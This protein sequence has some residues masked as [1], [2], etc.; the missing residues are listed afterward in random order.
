MKVAK[1]RIEK[2]RGIKD[3]TLKFPDHV[4]LVGDNNVGKSTVFEALDLVLGPDRLNRRPKID[5]HDFHLG[6]YVSAKDE[7]RK[8]VRIET[9]VTGLS[10]EQQDRFIDY[11]EWWH[12]TK[13][14]FQDAPV[15]AVDDPDVQ[16]AL[17]VTFIGFYDPEDDD[18]DGETYFSRSM[19]GKRSPHAVPKIG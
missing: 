14:E 15:S 9:T 3:A 16:A 4:V 10:S 12:T 11:V 18:F 6:E 1:L 5:E 2:F 19:G 8:E 7:L 13:Q 17:R